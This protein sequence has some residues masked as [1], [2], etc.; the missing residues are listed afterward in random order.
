MEAKQE[1][2]KTQVEEV[3]KELESRNMEGYYCATAE[4]ALEQVLSLLPKGQSVSW[5]GSKTLNQL[6]IKEKV[7]EEDYTVYDRA[8]AANEAEKD[9]IYHQALNCDYYLMSTNAIT[10]KGKLVNVDGNGNRVAA[11]IYGPQHVII[12]AGMNKLTVDEASARQRV[13]NHAAPINTQRLDM[14]TPCAQTGQCANCK[15]EDSIC[16]QTVITRLS[17]SEGRI[18]VVLVGEELGY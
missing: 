10:Q 18:K 14:E 17:R 15:A 6:G 1:Y 9:K 5:G 2:Y 7:H 3:I 11:L 12:V 8:E 16:S 4:E 13:R